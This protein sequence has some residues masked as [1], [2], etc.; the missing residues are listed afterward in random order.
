[1]SVDFF[2]E[3][4]RFL[5]NEKGVSA[6]EMSLALGQNESYINKIETGL[7]EV[8]MPMFFNICEYLKISP[9]VFFN[10]DINNTSSSDSQLIE[11]FRKLSP[12]QSKYIL[13][14][15]RDLTQK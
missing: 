2:R 13:L 8:S 14:L 3:R 1:M 15:L 7:R 4:L 9:S 11:Y 10:Q 6:R 12:E 5:R